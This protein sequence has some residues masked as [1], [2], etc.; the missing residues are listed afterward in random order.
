MPNFSNM[1]DVDLLSWMSN[2][3]SVATI[4][5][6]RYGTNAEQITNLTTKRDDLAAKLF[7]RQTADEAAKSAVVAQK[8]SRQSGEPDCSYLNTVIKVNTNISD[9]DKKAI[10]IE[11]NKSPSF[12]SPTR[13]E[14]LVG[15]GFEDGRNLLRWKRSENK[16]TTLFI[17][18]CKKAEATEFTYLDA[19]METSYEHRGV[20]PG[21]RCIYRVKA[22]HGGEES[23][24]SNEAAVY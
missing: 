17:I 4:D 9:A 24:Y 18:E 21:V 1:T 8:A 23:T 10:G 14:A 6:T 13:P 20:T 2:F 5:P 12:T 16:N 11:P 15:N 19:T 7:A 22:K 3:I